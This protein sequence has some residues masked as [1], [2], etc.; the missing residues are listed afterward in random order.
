MF[1]S[2]FCHERKN[3]YRGPTYNLRPTAHQCIL[4]ISSTA[5]SKNFGQRFVFKHAYRLCHTV[6]RIGLCNECYAVFFFPLSCFSLL[7]VVIFIVVNCVYIIGILTYL[8]FRT[9]IEGII[10]PPLGYITYKFGSST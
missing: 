7:Y 2:L 5:A 10:Q 9:I 3:L 6:S 8:Q 4:P 1:C